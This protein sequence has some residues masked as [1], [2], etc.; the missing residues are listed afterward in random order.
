MR[1]I[2]QLVIFFGLIGCAST[3]SKPRQDNRSKAFTQGSKAI[4]LSKLSRW[5]KCQALSNEQDWQKWVEMQNLCVRD[6]K[7][8][9]V[10]AMGQAMLEKFPDA[11][12]GA[13]YISIVALQQRNWLRAEWMLD[14]ALSMSPDVGLFYFQQGLLLQA[15]AEEGTAR[16]SF[17]RAY[18]LDPSLS[19]AV[20]YLAVMAFRDHDYKASLDFLAQLK[21]EDK[22][23]DLWVVEMESA[24]AQEDWTKALA[25]A[26]QLVNISTK[27][28]QYQWRL[29]EFLEQFP[30]KRKEALQAYE[31]VQQLLKNQGPS[32][33]FALQ[34]PDK[35]DSLRKAI[36]KAEAEAK[37]AV[38]TK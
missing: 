35:L 19:E 24:R 31:K 10:E 29:A 2:I 12:W 22:S 30:E 32:E 37:Q 28:V 4:Q 27:N 7:W 3:G 15:K 18:K 14:K 13:Y 34:L 36:A 38:E 23:V 1:A 33:K 11:P 6:K 17:L 21:A 5:K 25:A 9:T 26:Q 16:Q 20:K 8:S